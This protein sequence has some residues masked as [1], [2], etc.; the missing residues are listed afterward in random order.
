[1]SMYVCIYIYIYIYSYNYI[2]ISLSLS[3]YIYIYIFI[4]TPPPVD[5]GGEDDD[6]LEDA[7]RQTAGLSTQIGMIIQMMINIIIN[8]S[9]HINNYS[10]LLSRVFI[11]ITIITNIHNYSYLYNINNYSYL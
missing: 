10:Y 8:N 2:Y 11:F 9:T 5:E 3:I 1:M 4:C 7:R 6:A